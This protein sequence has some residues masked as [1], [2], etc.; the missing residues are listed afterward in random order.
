MWIIKYQGPKNITV[1]LFPDVGRVKHFYHSPARIVKFLI[2]KKTK[3]Q[4][5]KK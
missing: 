4:E 2:K 1:V 5:D 3:K